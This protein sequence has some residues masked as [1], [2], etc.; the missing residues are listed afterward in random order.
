MLGSV[1]PIS[2]APASLPP[3]CIIIALG[4]RSVLSHAALPRALVVPTH[5][6]QTER[7][8]VKRWLAGPH[9]RHAPRFLFVVNQSAQLSTRWGKKLKV[10]C[11]A[12]A[13]SG[14]GHLCLRLSPSLA[15]GRTNRGPA[16][17]GLGGQPAPW[18]LRA[19][20]IGPGRGQALKARPKLKLEEL[21]GPGGPAG[22]S[23]RPSASP[24]CSRPAWLLSGRG[25][26]PHG[27]RRPFRFSVAS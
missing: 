13:S 18:P 3:G 27:P 20:G 4:P 21:R 11:G 24:H 15:W 6:S 5:A 17:P 1:L 19:R 14:A 23:T 2:R 12:A 16:G 25:H 10:L 22:K 8:G 26:G 9:R 7:V